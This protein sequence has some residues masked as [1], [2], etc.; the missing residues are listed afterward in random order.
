MMMTLSGPKLMLEGKAEVWSTMTSLELSPKTTEVQI[1]SSLTPSQAFHLEL[2]IK[3]SLKLHGVQVA[4]SIQRVM[5]RSG[6]T[7]QKSKFRIWNSNRS[8]ATKSVHKENLEHKPMDALDR[9]RDRLE[10][11][12]MQ[13]RANAG[14]G[15]YDYNP[16]AQYDYQVYEFSIR[17][18]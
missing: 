3:E 5:G 7:K 1:R 6:W 13:Q 15:Y 4:T 8:S 18:S 16:I 14:Q 10:S 12:G 17:D 9:E 11:Q 2:R